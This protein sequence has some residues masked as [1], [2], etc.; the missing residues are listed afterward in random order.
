M[1]L[2]LLSAASLLS[3]ASLSSATPLGMTHSPVTVPAHLLN[4]RS[5]IG[6]I[7][8]HAKVYYP[9]AGDGGEIYFDVFSS[10]LSS[11]AD[12][13][14]DASLTFPYE[15]YSCTCTVDKLSSP[16]YNFVECLLDMVP[17]DDAPAG[18]P[19]QIGVTFTGSYIFTPKG[20]TMAV[21]TTPAS[22]QPNCTGVTITV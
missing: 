21:T 13:S 3:L 5:T 10:S 8:A 1:K 7:Q 12:S 16:I 20:M 18:A 11:S 9:P 22:C 15:V 6:D 17:D 4:G 14:C 2:Q 19:T